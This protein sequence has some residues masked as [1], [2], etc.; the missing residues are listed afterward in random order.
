MK[1]FFIRKD[2]Y[3]GGGKKF[4]QH[5]TKQNGRNLIVICEEE[6]LKNIIHNNNMD[7]FRRVTPFRN[8]SVVKLKNSDAYFATRDRKDLE[9]KIVTIKSLNLEK[10]SR[11]T[12]EDNDDEDL[13]VNSIDEV[14]KY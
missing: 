6:V 5:P 2:E 7:K 9:G 1:Y 4:I 14:L 13:M 10:N 11:F 3:F 8:G 12:F